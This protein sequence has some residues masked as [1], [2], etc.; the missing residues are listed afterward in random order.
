VRIG[1]ALA[2]DDPPLVR[3]APDEDGDVRAHWIVDT[4]AATPSTRNVSIRKGFPSAR[5]NEWTIAVLKDRTR[6]SLVMCL[7]EDSFA[8]TGPL[9]GD[10]PEAWVLISMARRALAATID[11]A[12]EAETAAS[13]DT[14]MEATLMRRL[15]DPDLVE[16]FDVIWSGRTQFGPASVTARTNFLDGATCDPG[17]AMPV[18]RV[19][20]DVGEYDE[21]ERPNPTL[22]IMVECSILH[23]DRIDGMERLR[24]ER[25]AERR[26][27]DRP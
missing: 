24:I 5:W 26:E 9:E 1:T 14:T 15:V 16:P 21:F 6:I 20:A 10:G 22:R 19:H 3:I 8:Q 18:G 23:I 4:I 12:T 2:A 7:H 13:I 11:H 17:P 25:E 27:K